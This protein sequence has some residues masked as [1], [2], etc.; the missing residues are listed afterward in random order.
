MGSEGPEPRLGTR[1]EPADDDAVLRELWEAHSGPVFAL[2]WRLTGDRGQAED[3]VQETFLRAW[4]HLDGLD[5]ARG[6]RPWLLTVTRNLVTDAARARRVR[7]REVELDTGL[8]HAGQP[9]IPD[10]TETAVESWL[11]ADAL[12]TLT[13][14]HRQAI[15]ETFLRGRPAAAAAA[16]LGVPEGTVRSRTYYGLRALRV[17]LE[18]RGV[19]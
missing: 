9:V 8:A 6:V 12:A 13:A 2:A 3:L 18:E 11:I 10:P 14:E 15:V 19:L 1:S 4:R 5:P 17:A 16:T 7:P